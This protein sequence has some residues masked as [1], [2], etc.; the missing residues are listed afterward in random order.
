MRRS[1]SFI[2]VF[3]A[4][5]TALAR[6]GAEP[7]P[8][9]RRDPAAQPAT[10]IEPH[11]H[12][13]QI[14]QRPMYQRWKLRWK[15]ASEPSG[16]GEAVRNALND[17]KHWLQENLFPGWPRKTRGRS[18]RRRFSGMGRSLLIVTLKF[19]GWAAM[20]AA[21]IFLALVL[22][23][24][25]RGGRFEGRS[26]RILSRDRMR[27]A[28]ESGEA[29]AMEIP[30][31]FA[32]AERLAAEGDF[33]AVYRAL[34]LALLSRLHALQKIDFR[35]NRTNWI[36]VKQFRGPEHERRSF[37]SL[38][39]LFDRVWYGLMPARDASIVTLKEQIAQLLDEEAGHA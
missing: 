4:A 39:A 38:T 12:L 37:S 21:I 15:M 19:L 11:E 17:Y 13:R 20:A 1:I 14:L 32:E 29:L 34:Y 22:H 10:K 25:L 7:S 36:Y 27:K 26:A 8:P 33:R 9:P 5:W 6:P 23:R 3:L 30:A 18:D 28:L 24:W 35:R 31:W 16:F 2:L